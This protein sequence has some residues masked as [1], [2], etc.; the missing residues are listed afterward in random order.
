[1]KNFCVIYCST[2]FCC[3]SERHRRYKIMRE[4]GLIM[5]NRTRSWLSKYSDALGL[6]GGKNLSNGRFISFM[7]L[8]E[9]ISFDKLLE[10]LQY[11]ND[12]KKF[13]LKL[14]PFG[15]VFFFT[16]LLLEKKTPN[17]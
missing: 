14:V 10:G 12:L 13:L 17:I 4:H 16:P 8:I 5:P 15:F 11:E 3:D 1:M 7:Q 6:S 2:Q 9:G